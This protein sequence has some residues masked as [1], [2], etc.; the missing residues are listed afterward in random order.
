[1][2]AGT[3]PEEGAALAQALL[4]RLLARSITIVATTHYAELKDFAHTTSFIANASVEFD[5]ETLSPTYRLSIGLPGRSNAFAIARRLG[6]C[7]KSSDRRRRSSRPNPS[8]RR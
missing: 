6:L 3:D 7:R 2:G 5:I 8:K 1:M 4:R